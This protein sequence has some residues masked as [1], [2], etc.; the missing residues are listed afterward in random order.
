[1]NIDRL[2]GLGLAVV[3]L[4]AGALALVHGH[5]RADDVA[6]K[7]ELCRQVGVCPSETLRTAAR[8][9]VWS[10]EEEA[11]PAA[12]EV[13][14]ELLPGDP[15]APQNWASLGDAL[16]QAGQDQASTEAYEIAV[17][18][19]PNRPE[20]LMQVANRAFE[21]GRLNE[22]TDL[23]KR[24]LSMVR[25]YDQILFRFLRLSGLS[26]EETLDKAVPHTREP[27]AAYLQN[28]IR[29]ERSVAAQTVWK[30]MA[31]LE[32]LT[33]EDLPAFT[34]KLLKDGYSRAAVEAQRLVAGDRDPDWPEGNLVFNGGFE[35]DPLGTDLDWQL[36]R[37]NDVKVSFDED[38]VAEGQRSLRIDFP[39]TE[40]LKFEH[41]SQT[42]VVEPGRSY[43]LT[44]MVRSEEIT[45]DEGLRME[46]LVR[47]RRVVAATEPLVGTMDW[48]ELEFTFTVPGD[49]DQVQLVLSRRRSLRIDSKVQ[50]TVWLDALGVQ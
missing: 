12:I 33:P 25:T 38:V 5:W 20:I 49:A 34:Q 22:A 26:V 32:L 31:E 41:V 46:A 27:L 9:L 7:L 45:T 2:R 28:T 11:L 36:R 44:I 29:T 15:A 17:R 50:G 23:A 13:Y 37:H 30:K 16:A 35:E 48:S 43:R 39:G 24:I 18:L 42:V 21:A 4:T 10:G 14:R 40:N 1:M 47:G 6:A 19:G 8:D 3:G